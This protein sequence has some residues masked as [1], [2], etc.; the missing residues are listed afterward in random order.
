MTKQTD[1]LGNSTTYEYSAGGYLAKVTDALG[2]AVKYSYDKL[3]NKLSMTDGR[4]KL[5]P[6][7]LYGPRRLEECYKCREQ[8]SDLQV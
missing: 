3:G 5:T 1:A 4:G 8:G 7:C 6:L 2:A